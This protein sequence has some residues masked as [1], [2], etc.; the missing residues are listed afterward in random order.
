MSQV[1]NLEEN[2]CDELARLLG[3]YIGIHRQYYR[4]LQGM[5]Q[6][7]RMSKV[8][9]AMEGGTVSKYKG[10]TLE[11]ISLETVTHS[12]E[13]PSSDTSEEE[14]TNTEMEHI[15]PV[16]DTPAREHLLLLNLDQVI[17]SNVRRE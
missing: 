5:L 1:L 2:E 11:D 16:T 8:L 6:L 12:N 4:L 14:C 7:A 13:A 15:L 9:L 17:T 3:H 10:M